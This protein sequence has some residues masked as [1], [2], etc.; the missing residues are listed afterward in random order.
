LHGRYLGYIRQLKPKAKSQVK[1]LREKKG[2]EV[3]IR[4]LIVW[5]DRLA[6]RLSSRRSLR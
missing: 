4:A 2:V 5:A 3:T 6:L 1:A